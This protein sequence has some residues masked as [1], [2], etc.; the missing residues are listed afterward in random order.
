TTAVDYIVW[1]LST[2]ACF[3]AIGIV[4]GINVFTFLNMADWV[5]DAADYVPVGCFNTWVIIFSLGLIFLAGRFIFR[6]LVWRFH[7]PEHEKRDEDYEDDGDY[8]D[9]DDD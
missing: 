2:L 1:H 9:D 7:P 6:K 3:V 4:V 5:G 8:E